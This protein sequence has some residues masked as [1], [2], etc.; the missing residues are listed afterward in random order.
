[1]EEVACNLCGKTDSSPLYAFRDRAHKVPGEFVL[2][3][4]D[5]CSL[6]YLSPRPSKETMKAFYP[7]KYAPFRP[8]I[9]DERHALMRWMRTRK[10]ARRRRLIERY[11]GQ[12][13]GSL[14]DVGCATG[15]FLNEMAQ[16]GWEIAGVEPTAS[17]VEYAR[18]RFA[19]KVFGGTL[20]EAPFQPGSFDVVTF[21]D[22]LEHT[23]SPA[24]DLFRAARLLRPD[25]L[26][27]INVPHW[28]S[29]A[30]RLFGRHW[31]GLDP[32]RH[33]YVFSR[34]TLTALLAKAG[35]LTVDWVCSVSG[36]FAFVISMEQWLETISPRL[37]RFAGRVFNMP[38]MRLPFEPWFSLVNW[39]GKGATIS[40][41]ARKKSP[42]S[43]K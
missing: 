34:E 5:H 7:A 31:L 21:W 1:M 38:G 25:G 18:D 20:T 10:L 29:L 32:P 6:I 8:A 40:V 36:Y 17:A 16:G 33:L 4:C 9:Q 35:F 14:L 3:R 24:E 30:R 37:S 27:V 26:L 15:L 22:V 11:S 28:D 12:K 39:L 41:F 2:R 43:S 23:F 42:Q 13:H 19:L